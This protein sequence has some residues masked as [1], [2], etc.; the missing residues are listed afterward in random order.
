VHP[1]YL[2]Y[3]EDLEVL[4]CLEGLE[5]PEALEY[6]EY[7]GYPEGLEYLED[8]VGLGLPLALLGLRISLLQNP[9]F[10]GKKLLRQDN[11]LLSLKLHF[12]I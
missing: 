8:L 5:D 7:L 1:V 6:P 4:E 11:I 3:L 12:L 10:E 9:P 2:A